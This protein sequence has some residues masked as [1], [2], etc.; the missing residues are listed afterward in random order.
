MNAMNYEEQE[1]EALLDA[2]AGGDPPAG[3]VLVSRHYESITRFFTYRLGPDC[4]DLV[5]DTFMGLQRGLG[6]FRRE[7]SVRIYLFKIARN[8]LLGAL[9]KRVR[10]RERFDPAETTMA[11][12]DPSATALRAAKDELKLLVAAL[13]CLP[14]DVQ[15]MLELHYWEQLKVREIAEVLELNINT[16]KARMSRGRKRL[17]EEMERIAESKVQLETTLNQ[18]SRW[19]V[20][21]R[22]E[23]EGAQ[24]DLEPRVGPEA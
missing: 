16:V 22:A 21:L 13:R 2:W 3:A 6:S 18:L 20:E 19:V 1:D 24:P 17:Y 4:E 23:L 7:C 11:S 9:R 10:E 12:L 5:Q 8:Q 15:I 14:I